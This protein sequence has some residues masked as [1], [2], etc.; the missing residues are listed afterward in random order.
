M[1]KNIGG[2]VRVMMFPVMDHRQLAI[3]ADL[4]ANGELYRV[5]E[6][7]MDSDLQND[8]IDYIVIS[9][10]VGQAKIEFEK[11]IKEKAHGTRKNKV[12]DHPGNDSN[13]G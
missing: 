2:D 7:I 4:M 8:D 10:F 11:M 5:Q 12:L 9:H 13:R 6:I 1:E 3:R